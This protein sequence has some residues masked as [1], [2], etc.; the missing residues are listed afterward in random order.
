MAMTPA[1]SI[2]QE[3]QPGNVAFLASTKRAQAL[4]SANS[5]QSGKIKA[6]IQMESLQK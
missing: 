2:Q 1:T 5:R 6:G 3:S 4:P